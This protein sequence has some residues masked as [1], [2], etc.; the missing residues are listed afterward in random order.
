[1]KTTKKDQDLLTTVNSQESPI[2]VN[3][4][5]DMQ[6]TSNEVQ[7]TETLTRSE[8]VKKMKSKI[9]YRARV[10]PFNSIQWVEGVVTGVLDD[11]RAKNPL[12]TVKDLKTGKVIRKAFGSDLIEILDEKVEDFSPKQRSISPKT[13]KDVEN[14]LKQAWSY[15]GRFTEISDNRFLIKSVVLDK[16]TNTVLLKLVDEKTN[17]QFYK[18]LSNIGKISDEIDPETLK[19]AEKRLMELSE[20]DDPVKKRE[21]LVKKMDELRFK[22][23]QLQNELIGIESELRNLDE[24]SEVTNDLE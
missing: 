21:K 8:V 15:V 2:Y 20:N 11:V 7:E 12:W 9:G 16:R 4:D 19:R 24:T 3:I 6:E 18:T 14:L 22:I 17:R 13:E 23:D 1:M 5:E 10:V